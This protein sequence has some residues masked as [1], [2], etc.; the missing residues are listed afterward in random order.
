M[1]EHTEQSWAT[2]RLLLGQQHRH[3]NT[4]AGDGKLEESSA[5][6]ERLEHL[7]I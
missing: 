3:T 4:G 5:K 1:C 7:V 6:G 2:V